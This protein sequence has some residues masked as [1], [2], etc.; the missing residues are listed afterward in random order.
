MADP[1]IAER[2]ITDLSALSTEGGWVFHALLGLAFLI[3]F[4][5]L[6]IGSS[7]SWRESRV[8]TCNQWKRLFRNWE[9]EKILVDQIR[10]GL[11]ETKARTME[12]IEHS[13]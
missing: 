9:K 2:F 3:V 4:S 5:I 12:E 11:P 8:L 1:G 7:M 10:S 13:L 6:L